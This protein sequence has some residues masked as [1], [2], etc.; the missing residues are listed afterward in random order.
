MKNEHI[1]ACLSF[2]PT[3]RRVLQAAAEAAEAFNGKLTAV[4]VETNAS[5]KTDK[6]NRD[7]LDQNLHAARTMGAVTHILEGED[8]SYTISEYARTSH[9]T[10]IFIGGSQHSLLRKKEIGSELVK[11]LPGVEVHVLPDS[12]Q[13]ESR[14]FSSLPAKSFYLQLKDLLWTLLI[15]AGASA[16]NFLIYRSHI[17]NSNIITLYLMAVLATS[18]LTGGMF[19]GLLASVLSVVLFNY[20]FLEPRFTLR[21]YDPEYFVTYLVT[22]AAAIMTGMLASRLKLSASEN[23]KISY[24]TRVLL[25]T[26]ELLQQAADSESIISFTAKQLQK[27]FDCNAVYYPAEE[28]KLGA[29]IVFPLLEEDRDKLVR[30]NDEK[31]AAQWC[32]DNRHSCGWHQKKYSDM[33]CWYLSVR[34]AETAYG[35]FGLEV[36]GR[37]IDH[38]QESVLLSILGECALALTNEENRREKEL[39]LYKANNEH[40]RANLLRSVSHDLRTPLTSISGQA[41]NLMKNSSAMDEALKKDIYSDIYDDSVWLIRMTENLL[42]ATRL[43]S[44]ENGGLNQSVGLVNDVVTE[45]L[46]HTD[47]KLSEHVLKTELSE[48]YLFSR[49]D[50]GLIEQ[51]VINL[52]NNAVRYT[53][54]GSV[55]TIRTESDGSFV[56]IIISDDGPGIAEQEK[57]HLFEMFSKTASVNSDGRRGLGIGLALCRSII[58]AH[59]GSIRLEDASP[60]GCIFTCSLPEERIELHE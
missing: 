20:L 43:E 18:A 26:S 21:V 31:E 15:M 37:R 4:F 52:V 19:Y 38:F 42:A 59:G 48:E 39:A 54:Q 8:V 22:F 33:A 36:K 14:F 1:L 57:E 17:P 34:S 50:A 27:L 23:A 16:V 56:K 24:R 25:D 49:M 9:V 11:L 29:M 5:R 60:H 35:V 7:R 55:I 28:D 58:E 2:S 13:S 30:L 45:A 3:N 53:P 51:V 40:F 41:S 10:K 6:A 47:R 44:S 12:R 32:F 46:E